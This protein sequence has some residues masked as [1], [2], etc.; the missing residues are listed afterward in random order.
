MPAI[1]FPA[2]RTGTGTDVFT[3][4]LVAGLQARDIRAEITWLPLRA[5]FAPWAVSAPPAP[6]WATI[7]HINTWLH[8]R[9]IP[10][11]LPVVATLHHSIHDPALRQYKGHLRTAYHRWWIS[12]IER[13][14]LRRADCVVA[15]SD[16]VADVTRQTLCDVPMQMI[17]NGVDTVRFHPGHRVR[18]ADEPFRL[19]YVGSWIAR[20]GVD[21]LPPIMRELGSGFELHYT[22]GRTA[23]RGRAGMPSNMFDLERLSESQVAH[24]MQS[25]DAFLFPSRSE[26]LPLVAIEA[27]ACGLPVIATRGSSLTEIVEN[28]V[29]GLLCPQDDVQAF[30]SA[31][32][33]LAADMTFC[34]NM[35]QAA[36]RRVEAFFSI[37]VMLDA[38]IHSYCDML[39][40]KAT[41]KA[42][43]VCR[44]A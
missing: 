27:M 37:E 28:E 9:F 42:A 14:T 5:E 43:R 8:P 1:W 10:K 12:L 7:C 17:H 31:I 41:I 40:Q 44:R 32:R 16:F 21:L 30:V 26:G 15:V 19:L 39:K 22:G 33:K 11:H 25:A 36:R 34:S 24:A 35:A 38:Y 3:E 20:K 2:V 13:S 4:R 23:D 29:T 18:S 6:A